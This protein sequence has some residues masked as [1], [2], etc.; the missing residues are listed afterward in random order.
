LWYQVREFAQ[1]GMLKGLY[2]EAIVQLC[3]RQYLYKGKKISV[4]T[5]EDVKLS[6]GRSPDDADALAVLVDVA[7]NLG[8]EVVR[9]RAAPGNRAWE[10]LVATM[11]DLN[12]AD[13]GNDNGGADY[14]VGIEK[15]IA[16]TDCLW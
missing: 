10:K 15:T 16:M 9:D 12:H 14:A 8:M 4:E 3:N 5:K 6:L 11:S 1:A 2:T 7:R 13:G